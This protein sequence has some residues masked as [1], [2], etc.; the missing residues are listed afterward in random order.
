M[1]LEKLKDYEDYI[2]VAED[3]IAFNLFYSDFTKRA[4]KRINELKNKTAL[5]VFKD[6]I[7]YR[8]IFIFNQ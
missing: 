2:G 6:N 8:V 7:I 1:V 4:E 5:V 3:N